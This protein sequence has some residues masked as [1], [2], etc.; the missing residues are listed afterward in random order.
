MG[1]N[2]YITVNCNATV[3]AFGNCCESSGG[4]WKCKSGAGLDGHC[5]YD[6]GNDNRTTYP[7]ITP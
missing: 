3:T 2:T 5:P 1:G 7:T 6:E 4:T